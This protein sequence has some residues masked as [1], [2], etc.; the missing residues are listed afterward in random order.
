MM[1]GMAGGSELWEEDQYRRE[2]EAGF[3]EEVPPTDV[4][5]LYAGMLDRTDRER[6]GIHASGRKPDMIPDP[7]QNGF[8]GSFHTNALRAQAITSC[9]TFE[10]S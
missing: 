8:N 1:E 9:G 10:S 3:F 4:G 6:A 5:L 2:L 7:F